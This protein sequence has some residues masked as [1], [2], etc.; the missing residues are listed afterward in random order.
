MEKETDLHGKILVRGEEL[1]IIYDGPSFDGRMEVPYL[2]SQL[3][4][5]E[6][7]INEIINEL[8]KSK[9]LD[10]PEEIRLYLK[11]KKGSFQEIISIVFNH[12]LTIAIIGGCIVAL[13]QKILNKPQKPNCITINIENMVG[14]INLV[15]QINEIVAPLQDKKDRVI[16][17]SPTNKEINTEILFDEKSIIKKVLKRLQEEVLIEVF[18]EEFFGY[19]YYMNV[20][21]RGLGFTLEGTN[22]HVPVTFVKP[23]A[24]EEL[25]NIFAEK[26]KIKAKATYRNKEL[27]RLE[28]I[29]YELKER[30][31][32]NNYFKGGHNK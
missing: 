25:K 23:P 19:L 24:L 17:S 16:I 30:K 1:E 15:N 5:I 20:D 22:K 26:I 11:L 3:K 13:F 27:H 2:I 9:K 12:P 31:D 18:E 32:L 28:I 7:I 14:N 21:N 4:S 6:L 8:Y 10:N 29:D